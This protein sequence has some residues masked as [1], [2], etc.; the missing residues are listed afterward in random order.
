MSAKKVILVDDSKTV[1]ETVGY[2]L[3]PLIGAGII[4]YESWLNP[5]ELLWALLDGTTNYDL[6]ISDINMPQMNGL[7][8]I[9]IIKTEPK[10]LYK[11][12]IV[13]STESSNEMKAKG[14]KA[15][16]IGWIVKPF[17][18]ER[19]RQVIRVILGVETR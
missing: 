11:P 9:E 15:G 1:L 14:R 4:E 12:I 7:E 16:V 13:L 6:L 18:E 17:N 3:E 19:L 10:L 5:K 2:A 8:L